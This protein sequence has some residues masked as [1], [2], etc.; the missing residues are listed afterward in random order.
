MPYQGRWL[1]LDVIASTSKAA[2]VD[3]DL[4]GLRV[5]VNNRISEEA[6]PAAI[7]TALRKW[8]RA[9]AAEELPQR[10]AYWA[11]QAGYAPSRVIV[12]DQKR[13]WGSCAPDGTLR[14]NWRLNML[15]PRLVDYVLVHEVAHLVRPHHRPSF[16]AE[17]E[18]ILPGSRSR[19]ALL[20]AAGAR[21]PM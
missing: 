5:S 11:A 10:V 4:L 12:R 8:F 2:R 16:W 17:V 6:R 14:L 15:E 7:E 9:R 3:L 19:R 21:L 18:R 1:P 13:R 20:R